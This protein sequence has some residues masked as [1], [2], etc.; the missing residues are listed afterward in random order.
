MTLQFR[1]EGK[2]K[3]HRRGRH[4]PHGP[5]SPANRGAAFA[6]AGAWTQPPLKRGKDSLPQPRRVRRCRLLA[7]E[8]PLGAHR[9]GRVLPQASLLREALRRSAY[10]STAQTPTAGAKRLRFE[11]MPNVWNTWKLT[12]MLL[13]AWEAAWGGQKAS[14]YTRWINSRHLRCLGPR[15]DEVPGPQ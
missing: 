10:S 12:R 14:L 2:K 13:T 15:G 6:G 9:A 4:L 1:S 7:C 5:P 11:V 8:E 3:V